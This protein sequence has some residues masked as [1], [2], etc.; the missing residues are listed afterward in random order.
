M[1]R[2]DRP[3]AA[4]LFD[5]DG[6]LVEDVPHNADPSRVVVV[7][8]AR[9][10]LDRLRHADVPIGVVSNQPG[11][12]RGLIAPIALARV[13]A[14]VEDLLGPFDVWAVCPHDERYGCACRK[15]APGLVLRAASVLGVAPPDCVVIGDTARDTGAA[16]AA[17]A[18][19]I[20]VPNA[21]TLPAE[22]RAAREVAADLAT[23][24]EM[25]LRHPSRPVLGSPG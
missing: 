4:V 18:R 16:R 5:R 8:G 15:P 11:V 24:V 3:P 17:L 19:G 12:A 7:P 21:R 9:E 1:A 23:A 13:H 25:A 2:I 6:T 22:V 10:A 14:R 20:L